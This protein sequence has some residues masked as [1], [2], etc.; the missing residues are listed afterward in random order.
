MFS[1]SDII[2]IAV[3]LETNGERLYRDAGLHT[4]SK[5]L[6]E[7]LEWVAEQ[8]RRHGAWFRDFKNKI[9]AGDDLVMGEMSRVLANDIVADQA[10]SLHDVDF[11]KVESVPE[12]IAIF[13][14]FESDGIL[15][16][17]ML[18]SFVTDPE[19][20]ENIEQIIREEQSHIDQFKELL[21][22]V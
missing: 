15:F 4:G 8:E 11:S 7:L 14:E 19:T 22:T 1:T 3:R 10:F 12:L 5:A 13:I 2:D 6:R 9:D 17:E 21:Q 20:V 16:Y 18:K